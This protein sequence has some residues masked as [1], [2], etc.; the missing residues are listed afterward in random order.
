MFLYVFVENII[1]LKLQMSKISSQHLDKQPL[2]VVVFWSFLP[3]GFPKKWR[4]AKQ[5]FRRSGA[6]L[7]ADLRRAPGLTSFFV[8]WWAACL[9]LAKSGLLEDHITNWGCWGS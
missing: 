2:K 3:I 1:E 7:P 4:R 9:S 5:P 6:T 8:G